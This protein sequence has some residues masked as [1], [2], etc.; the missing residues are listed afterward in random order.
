MG[1]IDA[2]H[3][4]L[5]FPAATTPDLTDVTLRSVA[6][7]DAYT[8]LHGRCGLAQ[9][10]VSADEHVSALQTADV[11]ELSWGRARGRVRIS[12][13][14]LDGGAW[15]R[16]H[17]PLSMASLVADVVRAL[18]EAAVARDGDLVV[19]AHPH[20]RDPRPC[21]RSLPVVH[22]IGSPEGRYVDDPQLVARTTAGVAHVFCSEKLSGGGFAVIAPGQTSVEVTPGFRLPRGA[23]GRQRL[24]VAALLATPDR[25]V[26]VAV[27]RAR[28]NAGLR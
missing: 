21:A 23:L 25:P 16:L 15:V 24:L 3:V 9:A 12:I 13:V 26:P 10:A 27:Q 2:T 18:L 5:Q 28:T 22:L 19:Q 1:S 4:Q 17:A 8:Q 11:S 6:R 20:D 14:A 7:G